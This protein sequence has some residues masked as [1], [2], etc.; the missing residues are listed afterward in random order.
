MT[1]RRTALALI[2]ILAVG[3]L[4]AALA[5]G[6][7]ESRRPAA[8][9][10][11]STTTTIAGDQPLAPHPPETV[12]VSQ[13]PAQ[14]QIDQELAQNIGS[15][16]GLDAAAALQAPSPAITAGWPKL[17]DANSPE[18][19]AL[20]FVSG[21]LNIDYAHQSRTGLG[22][23]LQAQEAP[24]ILPGVPAALADKLLYVSVLD[25]GVLGGQ[26]TPIPTVSQWAAYAKSGVSQ[27]VSG[28][29]VQVDPGWTQLVDS[30]WQPADARVAGLDVSGELT[31][32]RATTTTIRRF[33]LQ[34]FVGSARWHDGY[35]T[36]SLTGW[37][38]N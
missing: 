26:P 25:P 20:S 10:A 30:G 9:P 29:L 21:L 1:V 36:A 3:L 32:R 19:W 15:V 12:P 11:A 18:Q 22:A 7:G 13:S 23:W 27:S 16:A 38:V 14:V 28:L 5:L 33:S 37:E 4:A 8:K 35:G 17:A 31:T 34:L 24:M 6:S 2:G